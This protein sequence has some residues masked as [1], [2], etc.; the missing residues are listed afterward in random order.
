MLLLVESA[1]FGRVGLKFGAE[2]RRAGED[3][4]PYEEGGAFRNIA[5]G[6]S[7]TGLRAHTVRPYG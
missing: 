2:G 5:R 6:R 1:P 4:R 3:T 7:Q